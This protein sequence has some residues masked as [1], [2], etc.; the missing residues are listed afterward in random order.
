M[1]RG[2]TRPVL[3]WDTGKGVEIELVHVPAGEFVMGSTDD[4]APPNESPAHAHPCPRGYWIGRTPISAPQFAV[5][6]E[7][8]R[9]AR[10][11]SFW[12]R[13]PSDE[14]AVS[15]SWEEAL[16][17]CAWAGLDL[18]T[19]A[20]W[21]K[22][23]EGLAASRAL[24]ETDRDALRAAAWI[25]SAWSPGRAA[26]AHPGPLLRGPARF[27]S[28]HG[29]LD[30]VGGVLEWC[31]DLYEERAYERWATGDLHAVTGDERVVRGGDSP[32]RRASRRPSERDAQI[33]FRAVKRRP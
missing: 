1:R 9:R 3:V 28:V 30:L 7:A 18:P 32:T 13:S 5:F 31:A 22:A 21:E 33:G 26:L 15:V 14:P 16:E 8:T 12:S 27:E 24:L 23:A 6:A 20:E 29:A 25:V 11:R 17:F 4:S 10:R 2:A 19:E